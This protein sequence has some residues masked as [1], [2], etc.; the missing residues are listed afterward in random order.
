MQC[1]LGL[2]VEHNPLVGLSGSL[3]ISIPMCPPPSA[4]VSLLLPSGRA[5]Q[6]LW[7]HWEYTCLEEP[8]S[9][10][11]SPSPRALVCVL[12]AQSCPT[13]CSPMNWSSPGSSVHGILPARILEWVAIALITCWSKAV[14]QWN[15]SSLKNYLFL[16]YFKII[17]CLNAF[18]TNPQLY[19][20]SF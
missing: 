4:S 3:K 2:C 17:K 5:T 16:N 12:V 13:L 20:L 18:F 8:P 6:T 7:L 14:T 1:T 11:F 19:A 10:E 9:R 15:V